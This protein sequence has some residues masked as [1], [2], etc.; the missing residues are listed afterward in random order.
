MV[1]AEKEYQALGENY[2][3]RHAIDIKQLSLLPIPPYLTYNYK[4]HQ[5][6]LL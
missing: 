4:R 1:I 6:T 3:S 2:R 5:L